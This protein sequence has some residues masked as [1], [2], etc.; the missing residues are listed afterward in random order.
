MQ[1]IET[2]P[3]AD[4]HVFQKRSTPDEIREKLCRQV[5][6][7]ESDSEVDMLTDCES[8]RSSDLSELSIKH[9]NSHP[10]LT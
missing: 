10:E 1:A 8:Y 2:R 5:E 6:S 9:H 4:S 3:R 7:E